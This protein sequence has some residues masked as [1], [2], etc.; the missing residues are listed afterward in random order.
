MTIQIQ[1]TIAI[2]DDFR[3]CRLKKWLVCSAHP[4][5]LP[6]PLWRMRQ[7]INGGTFEVEVHR[8]RGGYVNGQNMIF[9]R[10][11]PWSIKMSYALCVPRAMQLCSTDTSMKMKEQKT[12]TNG[13]TQKQHSLP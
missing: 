3:S 12:N 9:Q 1:L 11:K 10:G 6:G 8:E 2:Q 13:T 5:N 4:G 7:A